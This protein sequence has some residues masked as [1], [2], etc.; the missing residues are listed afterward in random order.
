MKWRYPQRQDIHT[1]LR[2]A[3]LIL[4]VAILVGVAVL[5]RKPPSSTNGAAWGF[6]PEWECSYPGDGDPVCIKRTLAGTQKSK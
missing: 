3:A 6:G 4:V 5:P 2:V 1:V